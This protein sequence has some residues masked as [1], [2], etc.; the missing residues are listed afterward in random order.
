MI[1]SKSGYFLSLFK[2]LIESEDAK[3]LDNTHVQA[4]LISSNN[5]N[6]KVEDSSCTSCQFTHILA[7]LFVLL[8]KAHMEAHELNI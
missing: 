7:G 1:L 4:L 3:H 8:M 2:L 6:D 5:S